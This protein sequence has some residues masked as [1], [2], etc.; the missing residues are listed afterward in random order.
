MGT[1]RLGTFPHRFQSG[2]SF[3]ESGRA[4][5]HCCHRLCAQQVVNNC[6]REDNL[7]PSSDTCRT[8]NRFSSGQ[9]DFVDARS[10]NVAE[11]NATGLDLQVDW[12]VELGDTPGLPGPAEL[13]LQFIAS[14]AFENETIAEPGQSGLDCLGFFGSS[15]SGFNVFMQPDRKYTAN[16]NYR[17]GNLYSRLQWRHIPGL[18]LFPGAGNVVSSID[19]VNYL[20]WNFDYTI[21]DRYTL[22]LGINNMLDDEPPIVGFSLAGDANVDISLYDTLGRRF[23]G[24]VRMRL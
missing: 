17:T 20:D 18:D 2:Y 7:D 24:G 19:A 3:T 6:F 11:V 4:V 8:I 10:L 15:C 22:F 16:V 14:W 5:R 1:D 9:I 13:N 12:G 23:F 21:A